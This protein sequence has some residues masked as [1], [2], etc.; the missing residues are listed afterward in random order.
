MKRTFIALTLAALAAPSA[1]AAAT[2]ADVDR[3]FHPYKSGFPSL[4][5]LTPGVVVTPANI[6]QFKD[7]FDPGLYTM[8]K[9]GWVEIKV[10]P[11]T[12]F[13]RP[14]SY[15]EATRENL[16][17]TKLGAKNGEIEGFVAGR[18]FPEEPDV[19]DPRAGEKLAWNFKYGV[20]Y[21]DSGSVYPFYWRYRNAA[22]GQIERTIKFQFHFLNFMHRT[23]QAP[24]PEITPNPARIFRGT[25]AKVHDPQDLRNTQ[26]LIHRFEDDTK[27]DDA[28]LYLGFQR[29][30]RRLATGQTTDA[31]LGSDMMI[32]DF[33]GYN[34]R[35]S[36]M[37][38]AYKGVRNILVPYFNH[39]EQ[40]LTD[41]YKEADGYKF[42][43]FHGKGNCM[44]NVTY[45]LR[46]AY[47][48]EA[49]PVNPN[50]PVS[51]KVMYLDAQTMNPGRTVIYDRKGQLWKSF[52][53]GKSHPDHHLPQNKGSDV[54]ID[55]LFAQV[56]MQAMHCT[57][58]QFK[59]LIDPKLNPPGL[60]QVQHLRGGD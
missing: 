39:N 33:E 14:Q 60:F 10:G 55:A 6:E 3:S 8:V 18:P 20:N 28:Y 16:N 48:L 42:V 54:A 27:L 56:D 57:T 32:E 44:P 12:D 21:G 35:I 17:K 40:P 4:P 19:K 50:H 38:W 23:E 9:D 13:P 36:D 51:K 1:A 30:V 45:Q 43:D 59:V 15:I 7:A 41:E 2:D 26:L 47:V 11:S 31:F 34:G 24:V 37:N 29:R 46:K 53:I 49:T 22:T 5:G 58:G 25:Y 52:T